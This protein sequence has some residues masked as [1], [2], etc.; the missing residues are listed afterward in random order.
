MR[1]IDADAFYERMSRLSK[2]SVRCL[3]KEFKDGFFTA[4]N[5]MRKQPTV[6]VPEGDLVSRQYLLAEYDRQHKGPPG[7]ARKIIEEVPAI[8]PDKKTGHWILY[9][10]GSAKCSECR[11]IRNDAWDL[12]TWDNYCSHCGADMR[13]SH[14]ERGW[15]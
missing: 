1:S 11:H 15:I 10:N 7:R 5:M 12:D 14:A 8:V 9:E 4:L 2:D 3:N 6:D 13:K